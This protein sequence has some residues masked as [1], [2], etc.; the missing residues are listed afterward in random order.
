M[1]YVATHVTTEALTLKVH[2]LLDVAYAVTIVQ[3]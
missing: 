2:V 1:N 3:M